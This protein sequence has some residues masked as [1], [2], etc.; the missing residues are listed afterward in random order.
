VRGI[1][2]ATP[3]ENTLEIF[4]ILVASACLGYAARDGLVVLWEG[5]RRKRLEVRM[6]LFLS[7]E[8]NEVSGNKPAAR[9]FLQGGRYLESGLEQVLRLKGVEPYRALLEVL[10][11]RSA[12]TEKLNPALVC[13]LQILSGAAFG[14]FFGILTSG[15]GMGLAAA[16]LGAAVPLLWLNDEAQARE[17][18]ILRDFP[19]A[20]E[21]FSLCVEAGLTLDQA[22]AHYLR[23]ARPGP[24]LD[25][26]SRMVRQIQAGSTRKEALA[27]LSGRLNLTDFSLFASSVTHAE[28]SGTGMGPTLRR[29]A[30]GLRDKRTQRAEKAVQELP[31]KLLLPLLLF[32]MPVTLLVV[33]AP[34]LLRLLDAG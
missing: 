9:L 20:L 28:R 10:I 14:L 2:R 1:S 32:I 11:R 33:F 4:L 29:L 12:R 5:L 30:V 34:V 27:T 7:A 26:I 18:R 22:W 19:D 6:R 8:R 13:G 31:V 23:Q 25:E 17:R 24:L 15:F 16:A 3:R 21:K